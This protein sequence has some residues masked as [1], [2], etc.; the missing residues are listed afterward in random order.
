MGFL[1]SFLQLFKS[2]HPDRIRGRMQVE[3][4]EVVENQPLPLSTKDVGQ[5]SLGQFSDS[6]KMAPTKKKANGAHT[7]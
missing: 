3:R 2:P 1:W 5:N 6:T 7:K 4:K